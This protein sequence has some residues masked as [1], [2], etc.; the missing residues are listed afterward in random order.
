MTSASDEKWRPPNCFFSRVG[1][2]TY[3]HPCTTL[4]SQICLSRRRSVSSCWVQ[5]EVNDRGKERQEMRLAQHFIQSPC[6]FRHISKSIQYSVAQLTP[7]RFLFSYF[8]FLLQLLYLSVSFVSLTR[9][10]LIVVLL[11]CAS[12]PPLPFYQQFLLPS[13]HN[14][15]N[16]SHIK[17]RI[18]LKNRPSVFC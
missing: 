8:L 17:N 12:P 6:R 13:Y 15:C 3:Q 11:F 4:L 5:K 14:F 9:C 10:S 1:L 16:T 18:H 7:Q 2:R